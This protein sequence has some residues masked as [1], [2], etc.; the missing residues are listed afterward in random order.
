MAD[1]ADEVEDLLLGFLGDDFKSPKQI[2]TQMTKRLAKNPESASAWTA[3]AYAHYELDDFEAG[4]ADASKAIEYCPESYL[5]WH[6]RGACYFCNGQGKDAEPDLSEAIRLARGVKLFL[7]DTYVF[8]GG[9][10]CDDDRVDEAMADLNK[11]LKIDPEH[12]WGYLFRGNAYCRAEKFKLAIKD[13]EKAISISDRD[14]RCLATLATL[15]AIC[16][17]KTIRDGERAV[18]LAQEANDRSDNEYLDE[19]A[20]AYAETGDF[21]QAIKIEK[22]AIKKCGDPEEKAKFEKRLKVYESGQPFH[23]RWDAS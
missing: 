15:L 12:A 14:A 16:T 10:R 11:C 5:A 18:K 13:F 23:A 1:C 17:D 20:M 3:R 19:L 8:R 21:K 9:I 2:R 22:R 6:L 4:I 7:E